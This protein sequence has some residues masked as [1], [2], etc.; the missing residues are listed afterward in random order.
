[1]TVEAGAQFA[2]LQ[3]V[4]AGSCHHDNVDTGERVLMLSKRFA[5]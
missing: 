4:R 2:V 1:M 3:L 5:C